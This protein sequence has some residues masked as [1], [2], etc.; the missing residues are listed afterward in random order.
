MQNPFETGQFVNPET[1]G[2]V[3]DPRSDGAAVAKI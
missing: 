1:G 3:A 2:L